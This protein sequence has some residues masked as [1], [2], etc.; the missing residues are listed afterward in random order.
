MKK[1]TSISFLL[2]FVITGYAQQSYSDLESINTIVSDSSSE[3]FEI[4]SDNL[5]VQSALVTFSDRT[6]FENAYTGDCSIPLINEDF[7]QGPTA[8]TV[9]GTVI[10][11]DGDNCFPAGVLED[12]FTV[13]ALGTGSNDVVYLNSG[14]VG[15]VSNLVGATSFA[16]YTII[17][18][19]GADV[20]AVG[21]D[22]FNNNSLEADYRVY[23][24]SDNLINTFTLTSASLVTENFFGFISDEPISRVEIEGDLDDGELIGNLSFGG[25][26][27]L[28]INDNLLSLVSVYP[29]PTSDIINIEIPPSVEITNA[30]LYNMLGKNIGVSLTSN[31]IDISNLS[32]GIYL[33]SLETNQGSL[34]QK[35]VKK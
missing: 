2:V 14:A 7:S 4:I 9:C 19:E 23:D 20:Y 25:C 18:F 29:N 17:T 22:I 27:A 34:T 3:G 1:I 12:G 33:L 31:R 21:Q 13:T 11:N 35:V 8:I 10:T 5:E 15:N 6:N 24:M 32:S 28:S 26:D 30:K 16:D